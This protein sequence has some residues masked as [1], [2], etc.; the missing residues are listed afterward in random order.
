[1]LNLLANNSNM[2]LGTDIFTILPNPLPYTQQ[3]ACSNLLAQFHGISLLWALVLL[4]LL[5]ANHDLNVFGWVFFSFLS[6]CLLFA[7]FGGKKLKEKILYVHLLKQ[8]F[9]CLIKLSYWF[10][11][12]C[13]YYNLLMKGIFFLNFPLFFFFKWSAQVPSSIAWLSASMWVRSH[14]ERPNTSCA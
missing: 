6:S 2:Y 3:G 10:L 9:M 5:K 8:C 11:A 4:K 13:G 7:I 12:S 14:P 1:M